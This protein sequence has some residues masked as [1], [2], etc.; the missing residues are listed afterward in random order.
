M[1]TISFEVKAAFCAV[2]GA[3]LTVGGTLGAAVLVNRSIQEAR[4]VA[5]AN[6]SPAIQPALVTEGAKL[7]ALNCS[8]CH[9]DD[10]TGDEGPDLHG[11]TKSDE[12]ISAIITNGVKGEMPSFK[13]KL[14][15]ADLAVLVGF[16]RSL[17]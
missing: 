1:K 4:N 6:A 3:L 15:D 16:L 7:F 2:L 10:A 8:H 9:A 13:K 5:K 14:G 11:V 17:K 12:R